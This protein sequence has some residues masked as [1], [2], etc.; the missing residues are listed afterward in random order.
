MNSKDNRTL[1]TVFFNYKTNYVLIK[2]LQ[3]L[4]EE[5]SF[6]IMRHKYNEPVELVLGA[7]S[8]KIFIFHGESIEDF[9]KLNKEFKDFQNKVEYDIAI[10]SSDSIFSSY[11]WQEEF[12]AGFFLNLSDYKKSKSTLRNLLK[13]I[14][15]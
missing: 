15:I 12:K 7:Y 11:N 5:F 1:I 9:I 14:K 6:D 2:L 8:Q 10:I 13:K 4:Q 3:E